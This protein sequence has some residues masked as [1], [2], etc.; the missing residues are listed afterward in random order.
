[1]R[2]GGEAGIAPPQ[3]RCICT[4]EVRDRSLLLRFVIGPDGEIVPDVAARL[5]G[6]GLWLTP[7][8]DI[9]ERAVERRLFARVSRRPLAVPS[10]LADRVEALLAQRCR[11]GL[12][13]ARR[14]GIAVGGFEKVREALR[15][16]DAAVLFEA[17][18][19]AEGGRRKMR[20]LGRGL[21][22]AVALTA[23]EIGAAFGRDHVVHASVG[24]GA[25]SVRLL[26]DAGKLAGFRAGAM[27]ERAGEATPRP[28]QVVLEQDERRD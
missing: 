6:R 10:G 14:A 1:L 27:V 5:P 7:R 28:P 11:D 22:I 18:D 13:L 25:L 16:G 8:R 9:V 24:S 20:G 21:S 2:H 19:A 12:G 4:G 23:A 15:A 26:A 17:V 3:R